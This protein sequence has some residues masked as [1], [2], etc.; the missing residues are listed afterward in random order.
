MG[1]SGN[2]LL[3]EI[4]GRLPVRVGRPGGWKLPRRDNVAPRRRDLRR[5][6][7]GEVASD[8]PARLF[9]ALAGAARSSACMSSQGYSGRG[10]AVRRGW[11]GEGAVPKRERSRDD[12]SGQVVGWAAGREKRRAV[13]EST[14]SRA[15]RATHSAAGGNFSSGGTTGASS[16]SGLFLHQERSHERRRS[17][18]PSLHFDAR[19]PSRLARR[20]TGHHGPTRREAESLSGVCVFWPC[21]RGLSPVLPLV[22]SPRRAGIFRSGGWLRGGDVGLATQLGGRG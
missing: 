17:L 1:R 5:E 19:P 15:A 8:R 20:E 18:A 21:G 6:T 10:P 12:P 9:A 7:A 2:K 11:G 14:S 3:S 13:C 4:S 16:C 22:S